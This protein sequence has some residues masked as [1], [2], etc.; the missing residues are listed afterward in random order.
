MPFEPAQLLLGALAGFAGTATL[1][2]WQY[3]RDLWLARVERFCADVDKAAEVATE[4]WLKAKSPAAPD[5][6]DE[7]EALISALDVHEARIIGLQI[8]VD[9][10]LLCFADRLCKTDKEKLVEKANDFTLALTGGMFGSVA[11]P[12]DPDR[13]RLIQMFASEMTLDARTYAYK[14]LEAWHTFR[15]I[16]R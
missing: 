4:Y 9:G 5:L 14:A 10:G 7:D 3:R 1:R 2:W 8:R 13:A 16:S 11:R 12:A 15:H 6:S